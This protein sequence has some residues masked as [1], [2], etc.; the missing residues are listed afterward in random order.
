M[1][2]PQR[3]GY[4]RVSTQA[5]TT[6][7]QALQLESECD[8]M[9]LEKVSAVAK[10]RPVFDTLIASLLPGDTFVVVDLDRAFRSAID[11]MLVANDLR[12]RGVHFRILRLQLDT[13]TEEGELFYTMLA[14]FA[15]Y[16]RR[17]IARRTREGLVAARRRGKRLG[18][19]PKLNPETISGAHEWIAETG[20]PCRYVAALLG[21]SRLTLQR[22]FHRQD[23]LYPIPKN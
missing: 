14:G 12:E 11:A 10:D 13:A 15:Q 7:R 8:E 17:I 6:D 9:Y 22:A 23:L 3:L 18:R 20:L 21:V 1:R 2:A 19:P 5:Q 16:E 4:I